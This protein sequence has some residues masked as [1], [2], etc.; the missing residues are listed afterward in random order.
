MT[1]GIVISRS[2]LQFAGRKQK[3]ERIVSGSDF[4]GHRKFDRFS[5][6]E[7]AFV[8]Q[9][10]SFYTASVSE[11]SWPYVQHR[12]GPQ[13]FLKVLDDRTLAFIDHRGNRQYISTGNLAE[14]PYMP[15]SDGLSSP[16]PAED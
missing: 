6:R 8:A 12:G 7:I 13:G 9:R 11:T 4:K 3:W 5:M 15:V 1:Y 16:Y 2:R 10:D 14:R